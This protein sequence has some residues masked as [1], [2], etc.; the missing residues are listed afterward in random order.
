MSDESRAE[1]V[2][3]ARIHLSKATELMEKIDALGRPDI[4]GERDWDEW[5]AGFRWVGGVRLCDM[6]KGNHCRR[7]AREAFAAGYMKG[8]ERGNRG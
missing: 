2:D 4:R 3:L 5:E 1:L 8:S 7:I 6:P